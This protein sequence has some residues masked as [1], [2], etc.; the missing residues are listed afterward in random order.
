MILGLNTSILVTKR[1]VTPC[2][3]S[4]WYT[5]AALKFLEHLQ[6][7]LRLRLNT[8]SSRLKLAGASFFASFLAC[9]TPHSG[10]PLQQNPSPTEPQS[11]LQ[12]LQQGS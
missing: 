2:R 3:L 7:P 12:S 6:Q 10:L 11:H 5:S 9:I 1:F 4:M 8:E